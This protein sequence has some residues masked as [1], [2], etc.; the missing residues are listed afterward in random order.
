MRLH[1][2]LATAA[3]CTFLFWIS[4]QSK[5]PGADLAFGGSDKFAHFVAYGLLAALVSA[6][7]HRA[8]RPFGKTVIRW[9]PVLFAGLYGISDEIHQY[10][11]PGRTFSF[12]DMVADVLGAVAAQAVCIYYFRKTA[13][14]I[15]CEE[16]G[17]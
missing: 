9:A 16:Q 8:P 3:Y 17:T 1:Y 10:F 5:L 14:P 2:Y 15:S 13:D 4:H 12:L 11:V 7:L 6:G